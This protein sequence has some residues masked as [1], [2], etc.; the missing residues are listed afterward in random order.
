MVIRQPTALR[1]ACKLINQTTN[2]NMK[3]IIL[4]CIAAAALFSLSG[5]DTDKGTHSSTTTT[6]QTTVPAPVTTT[7]TDTQT[8]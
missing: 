5:C 4:S 3:T 1:C 2:K 7:T 8:K 6:Q